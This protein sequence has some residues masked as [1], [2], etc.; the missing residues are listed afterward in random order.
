MKSRIWAQAMAFAMRY[1][2]QK[3]KQ[4]M[5]Q[6]ERVLKGGGRIVPKDHFQAMLQAVLPIRIFFCIGF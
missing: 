2:T 3:P 5:C 4:K 1:S 6:G